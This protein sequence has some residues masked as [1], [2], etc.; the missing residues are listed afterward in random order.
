MNIE[1]GEQVA[2][3]CPVC[4]ASSKLVIRQ[5]KLTGTFFLGCPNYPECNYSQPL[6]EEVRMDAIGAKKL[7]GFDV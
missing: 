1:I 6:P 3:A 2:R 4:G 5:N 7:P